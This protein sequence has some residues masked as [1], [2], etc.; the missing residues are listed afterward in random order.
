MALNVN[1]KTVYF[2]DFSRSLCY[3]DHLDNPL[4]RVVRQRSALPINDSLTSARGLPCEALAKQGEGIQLS[5]GTDAETN[6][7]RQLVSILPSRP[8]G[9]RPRPES[10]RG[11]MAT[12]HF[13]HFTVAG[14]QHG[15]VRD[16]R[17][18][19]EWRP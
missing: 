15:A 2:L 5:A 7:N 9:K 14:R 1:T 8:G 18:A 4:S 19:N 12:V 3:G 6:G 11:Q 13:V 17:K 10:A 16:E